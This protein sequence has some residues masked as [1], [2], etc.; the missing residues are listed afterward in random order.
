MK[1]Y[2]DFFIEKVLF[3]ALQTR[4]NSI[5]FILNKEKSDTSVG[6]KRFIKDSTF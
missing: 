3:Q 4:L 5:N 1:R 2:P 6:V